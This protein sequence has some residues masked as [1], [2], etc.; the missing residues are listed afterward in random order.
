MNSFSDTFSIALVVCLCVQ[1][2]GVLWIFMT[3]FPAM[4]EADRDRLATR[5]ETEEI[6]QAS[7]QSARISKGRA[8]DPGGGYPEDMIPSGVDSE[9]W[10][11]AVAEAS[12][13]GEDP[14]D[15]AR[16]LIDEADAPVG[17]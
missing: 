13:T 8:E 4:S 17:G 5:L 10:G 11:F 12:Q 3:R 7:R 6:I 9:T 2:L 16:R 1:S 15:V 14:R